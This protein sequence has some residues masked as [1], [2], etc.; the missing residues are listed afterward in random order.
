MG[1]CAV[2]GSSH[3]ALSTSG[4]FDGV[5]TGVIADDETG[6]NDGADATVWWGGGGGA[7]GFSGCLVEDQYNA[8]LRTIPLT[9][10]SE[11]MRVWEVGMP[12]L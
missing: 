9:E 10:R 11:P 4:G 3:P 8:I 2:V 12:T 7:T 6:C 1:G 5:D